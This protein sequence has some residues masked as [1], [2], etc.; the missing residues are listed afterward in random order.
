MK[1]FDIKKTFNDL[2]AFCLRP[3]KTYDKNSSSIT[4]KGS[5]IFAGIVTVL[6]MV[7]GI[8]GSLIGTIKSTS[9]S[10]FGGC[11]TVWFK[12]FGS[13]IDW[14]LVTYKTLLINAVVMLVVA[15][16]FY[17]AG[18]VIK[19][20]VKFDKLLTI[21]AIVLIPSIVGTIATNFFGMFWDVL[22]IIIGLAVAIFEIITFVTLLNKEFDF[23]GDKKV[24]F[25]TVVFTI[26][27]F[28]AYL[29]IINNI[30]N[31]LGSSLSGLLK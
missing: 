24:I 15:G 19:K 12:N 20:E 17:L 2:L 30:G 31:I 16:I 21:C 10:L 11:E 28:I 6:V 13:G 4:V 3:C 25:Y 1:N 8:L 29:L 26:I 5:F 18:L 9:C 14:G 23:D 22:G 27:L 7:A